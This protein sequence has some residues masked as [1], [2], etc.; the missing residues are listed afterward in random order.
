MFEF[1]QIILRDFLA[2]LIVL[3]MVRIAFKL[4]RKKA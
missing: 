4:L 3:F 2:F 1:L